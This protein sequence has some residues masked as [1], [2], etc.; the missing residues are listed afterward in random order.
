MKIKIITSPDSKMRQKV[1]IFQFQFMG[2]SKEELREEDDKYGTIPFGYIIGYE[3]NKIIGVVNLIKRKIKFNNK[4]IILGGIGGVCTHSK[5]LKQRV[6]TK[7][8]KKAMGILKENKCDLAFLCTD[9]EKLGSLYSQV[10]FI[11]LNRGYKAT[12]E[13]KRIYRD[14]DGMIA[15]L[16]SKEIFKDILQDDSEFDLQGKNW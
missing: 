3:E 14:N 13:S 16:N 11:P 1:L 9:I 5:F 8:L 2:W 10:G 6:A 15:P 12:G 7:L 4:N